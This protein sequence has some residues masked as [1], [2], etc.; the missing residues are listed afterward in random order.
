MALLAL[1]NRHG[2][3]FAPGL[4]APLRLAAPSYTPIA[5]PTPAPTQSPTP[6]PSMLPT[7]VPST[8]PT[9]EPTPAATPRPSKSPT[10]LPSVIPSP[11][12]SLSP[13]FQL[14]DQRQPRPG[15]QR[16]SHR[17][18]HRPTPPHSTTEPNSQQ[19]TI[20][21][22]NAASNSERSVNPQTRRRHCVG[23]RDPR[24]HRMVDVDVQLASLTCGV[25]YPA[26]SDG[27][28]RVCRPHN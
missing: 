3:W 1:P 15:S 10:P 14:P 16:P 12:P 19:C 28:R 11:A 18:V 13:A 20:S 6:V 22:A 21:V 4:G 9:P 25:H 8:V 5:L 17:P 7:F 2:I 26:P 23:P 27:R 24:E